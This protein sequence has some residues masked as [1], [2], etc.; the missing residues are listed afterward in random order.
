M[1]TVGL[2]QGLGSRIL[3]GL[4][5]MQK[6]YMGAL[7]FVGIENNVLTGCRMAVQEEWMPQGRER[8][9]WPE[10]SLPEHSSRLFDPG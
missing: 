7:W 2:L 8:V 9:R 5:G 10:T 6:D 4:P 3:K 1:E